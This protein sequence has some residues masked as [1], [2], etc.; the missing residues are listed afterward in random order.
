MYQI[1]ETYTL[2][3][4]TTG[5]V[6]KQTKSLALFCFVFLALFIISYMQEKDNQG[7]LSCKKNEKEVRRKMQIKK[8]NYK[9][10]K[11]KNKSK[12]LMEY[13]FFLVTL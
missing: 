4:Q 7:K 8:L 12:K 1:N 13:C 5:Y 3:P 10:L 6:I 11:N 2:P 9:Q